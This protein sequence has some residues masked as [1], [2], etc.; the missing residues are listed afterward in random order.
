MAVHEGRI[1]IRRFISAIRLLPADKPVSNP[2]KWY[3]T[4]KEHWLRWLGDY[5][6]SGAHGRKTGKNRDAQYAYNHIVEP[7][8]LLWLVAA[9]R[10]NRDLIHVASRA[11]KRAATMPGKSASIRKHVPWSEVADALWGSRRAARPRQVD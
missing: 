11:S 9:A 5:H 4:Q 3:K 7:K 8:M 10:V 2:S 6:T 1:S